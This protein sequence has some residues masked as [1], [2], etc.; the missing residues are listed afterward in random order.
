M[1]RRAF[2]STMILAILILGACA[3]QAYQPIT[4]APPETNVEKPAEKPKT[5]QPVADFSPEVKDLLS[6]HSIRVKSIFYKY[7]GP[8]TAE[9]LY[10]FYIKDQKIKYSPIR[11]IKYFDKQDSYNYIFIDKASGTAQS[12]CLD[13]CTYPGKKGD[14]V[15]DNVYIPTI[16]DWIDGL[17]KAEKIGEEVIDSRS[18]WKLDTNK[19]TLWIDTF[20]GIPLKVES[21]GKTYRFQQMSVNGVK[22]SN[23]SP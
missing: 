19:G 4:Y 11:N 20:Y 5:Q 22:D 18:T 3:K 23:V 21:G 12:Y 15:Y 9:F 2:I 6:R 8:E 16:F 13:I 17:T 10:D 14:L 1:K 7:K